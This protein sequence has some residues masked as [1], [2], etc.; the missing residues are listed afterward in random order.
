MFARYFLQP[1]P[2]TI[3]ETHLA[4]RDK[5]IEAELDQWEKSWKS[6]VT[7]AMLANALLNG[8]YCQ[9][10]LKTIE[11]F[12]KDEFRKLTIG[13]FLNTTA[14]GAFRECMREQHISLETLVEDVNDK[15]CANSQPVGGVR[16]MFGFAAYRPYSSCK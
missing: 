13:E 8:A 10:D 6:A 16:M 14:F 2:P 1:T 15:K 5:R 3:G 7:E 11:P 4:L 9:I 12:N